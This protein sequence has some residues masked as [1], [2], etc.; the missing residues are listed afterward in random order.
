MLYV[1]GLANIVDRHCHALEALRDALYNYT[2]TTTTT[3]PLV[4]RRRA[5]VAAS[6]WQRLIAT[7]AVHHR[8]G[9]PR[10]SAGPGAD[11][12]T[13]PSTSPPFPFPTRSPPPSG[14]LKSGVRGFLPWENFLKPR[15]L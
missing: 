3:T 14:P 13:S 1:A 8:P 7:A 4:C 6:V 15:S 12:F 11:H 10:A 5:V 2:T 9:P